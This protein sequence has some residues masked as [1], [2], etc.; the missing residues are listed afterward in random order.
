MPLPSRVAS[1]NRTVSSLLLSMR[2]ARSASRVISKMSMSFVSR[3]LSPSSQVKF[4]AP[5]QGNITHRNRRRSWSVPSESRLRPMRTY[6][7][8]Q[9]T[10]CGP[11]RGPAALV[12]RRTLA[13]G[14]T[15]LLACISPSQVASAYRSSTASGVSGGASNERMVRLCI[16]SVDPIKL[17]SQCVMCNRQD[18]PL[19]VIDCTGIYRV[20]DL[21]ANP[22]SVE[23]ATCLISN[24]RQVSEIVSPRV[25]PFE[26]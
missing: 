21:I 22:L 26:L 25:L 1:I 15:F 16:A 6:H 18:F 19:T 23:R 20:N 12:G 5:A 7:I 4:N 24:C 14:I 11:D 3:R 13:I 10:K 2:D 17:T 8:S 9:A